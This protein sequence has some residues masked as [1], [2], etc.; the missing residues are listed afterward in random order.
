MGLTSLSRYNGRRGR[1]GNR[2]WREAIGEICYNIASQQSVLT[3][4]NRKLTVL[5]LTREIGGTSLRGSISRVS[6]GTSEPY[7]RSSITL[8]ATLFGAIK[9]TH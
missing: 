9:Y 7:S 8:T 3:E 1:R 5:N 6:V 4:D 2:A